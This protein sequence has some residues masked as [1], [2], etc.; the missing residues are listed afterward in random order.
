MKTNYDGFRGWLNY[1]RDYKDNKDNDL[2]CEQRLIEANNKVDEL[3]K[4]IDNLKTLLKE[5]DTLI[6]LR[7]KRIETT[8]QKCSDLIRRND[9]LRNN[10]ETSGKEIKELS[11][12]LN[13]KELARRKNAGAIGGLKARI[14]E[15]KL[16]L[17]KANHKINFLENSRHAPSKEEILAYE[18][19]MK[20]VEKRQRGKQENVSV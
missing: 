11:L 8:N 4:I 5:K 18:T 15:L 17:D 16:A 10:L 13:E 7:N 9:E 12:K 6:T 1:V 14:N 19:R 3:E 20:E 2:I